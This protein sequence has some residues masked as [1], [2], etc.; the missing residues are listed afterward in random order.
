MQ[1]NRYFAWS[2]QGV[3]IPLAPPAKVQLRDTFW[4]VVSIHAQKNR[5]G[6]AYRMRWLHD[7]RQRS[8]TFENLAAAERFKTLLELV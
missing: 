3:R 7:G 5:I 2:R 8:L 4:V 6:D 1:V